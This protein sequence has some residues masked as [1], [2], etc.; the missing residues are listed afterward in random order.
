MRQPAGVASGKFRDLLLGLA[1]A[2]LQVFAVI[3]C[4]KLAS[5]RSTTRKP[6]RGKSIPMTLD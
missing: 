3:E 4:R 2:Y 1:A 6:W 5:P